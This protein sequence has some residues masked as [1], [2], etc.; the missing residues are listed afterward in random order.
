[1][2]EFLIDISQIVLADIVLSGDNALIIGMA[3]ASFPD[4][5]RKKIIFFGLLA[6]ALLRILFAVMASYLI[7]IPGLLLVGALLLYWVCYKFY[8]DIKEFSKNNKNSEKEISK[9]V[10]GQNIKNALITITIADISMSLDNVIAITAIARDNKTLLV[11]GIAFAIF[12]M[13]IFATAIV[14]L[15]IKFKWVSYIGLAFLMY[16]SSKMAFDGWLQ[17]YP[18]FSNFAKNLT[19]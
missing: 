11:L 16:L 17:L 5:D 9:R 13:A 3:A 2:F 6:A 1:M 4:K 19:I 15:L 10:K 14:K 8:K 18:Y 7:T 12:I